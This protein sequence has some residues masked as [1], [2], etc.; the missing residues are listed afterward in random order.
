MQVETFLPCFPGF[1]ET[2]FEFNDE[3]RELESINEERA[4][5][6]LPAIA[7]DDVEWSYADYHQ[8][9]SKKAVAYIEKMLNDLLPCKLTFKKLQS[10]REYNFST[11]MII[12]DA[13]FDPEQLRKLLFECPISAI[14]A[15]LENFKPSSGFIPFSET[16]EKA[17]LEYW[18][19]TD[20]ENFHDAG[21]TMQTILESHPESEFDMD[22]FAFV[23]THEVEVGIDNYNEIVP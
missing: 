7:Y 4:E 15:M 9:V 19:K 12:I 2:N 10:P 8:N 20:F 17:S 6:G 5:I 1:Y 22:N 23:S 3:G 11:D 14:E 21:W 16:L 13:E 18:Q